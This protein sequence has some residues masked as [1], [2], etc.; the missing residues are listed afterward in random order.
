V[1]RC[2][3]N[4]KRIASASSNCCFLIAAAIRTF[5]AVC[6][7]PELP[8]RR[9][10]GIPADTNY[11]RAARAQ[12]SRVS[13]YLLESHIG[14]QS[15]GV[16]CIGQDF[17]LVGDVW[18]R[19]FHMLVNTTRPQD[20]H[21][22]GVARKMGWMSVSPNL[23]VRVHACRMCVRVCCVAHRRVNRV[24][25]IGAGNKDHSVPRLPSFT[26]PLSCRCVTSMPNA[27]HLVEQ[28]AEQTSADLIVIAISAR[29]SRRNR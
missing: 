11:C 17:Q 4:C 5:C 16:G 12:Q 29:P 9:K 26:S 21:S 13:R 15:H 28:S 20:L 14:I 10:C 18:E 2:D 1:S 8:Q 27:I 22:R 6:I 24:S 19:N 7:C 3:A 25:A 23:T